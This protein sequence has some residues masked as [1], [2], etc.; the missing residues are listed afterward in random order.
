MPLR[1]IV[2]H[3]T[4]FFGLNVAV[5]GLFLLCNGLKELA[6]RSNAMFLSR[7]IFLFSSIKIINGPK[8]IFFLAVAGRF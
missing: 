6:T 2:R 1:I 8:K 5:H 4:T 7:S 3:N